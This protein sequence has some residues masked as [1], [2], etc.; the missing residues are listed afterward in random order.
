LRTQDRYCP[1]CPS[2]S[3]TSF[4]IQEGEADASPAIGARTT[5]ASRRP[6]HPSGRSFS[7]PARLRA[8]GP[9]RDR[10][11]TP[12][13]TVRSR[14]E[15]MNSQERPFQSCRCYA[16]RAPGAPEPVLSSAMKKTSSFRSF[17]RGRRSLAGCACV[18]LSP[19]EDESGRPV[20]KGSRSKT[21]YG[22]P[23]RPGAASFKQ[24][25]LSRSRSPGD[26]AVPE[27]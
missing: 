17:L 24:H 19:E 14:Y 4:A 16:C 12:Q 21:E 3:K 26:N 8:A 1:P 10:C 22:Q 7:A 23:A 6:R 5:S 25:G 2:R 11:P 13:A 20:G 9:G 27:P 18:S 15:G